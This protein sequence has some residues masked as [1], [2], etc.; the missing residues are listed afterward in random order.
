MN[1]TIWLSLEELQAMTGWKNKKR[2]SAWLHAN[3]FEF[4]NNAIGLPLI[5][6]AQVERR[7]GGIPS[8]AIAADKPKT[9]QLNIAGLNAAARH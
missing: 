1:T 5:G 7:L 9:K 3:G 8:P 2:I 6:R 4:I